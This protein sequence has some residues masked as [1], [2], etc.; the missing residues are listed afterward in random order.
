M[1]KEWMYVL[2]IVSSLFTVGCAQIA[3]TGVA[4]K[5]TVAD[6]VAD[7]AMA[8]DKES[9][10]LMLFAGTDSKYYRFD[11]AHYEKSL[12]EGKIIFLIFMRIGVQYARK[13]GQGF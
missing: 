4:D 10:E 6:N 11:K 9:G 1:K 2:L 13:K 8:A 7:K 3:E 5:T 12:G